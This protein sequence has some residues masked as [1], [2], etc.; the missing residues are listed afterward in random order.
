MVPHTFN[1]NNEEQSGDKEF[2]YSLCF[3]KKLS[4]E[5]KEK[6]KTG[7]SD[8][9]GEDRKEGKKTDI[10]QCHVL[11]FSNVNSR[12]VIYATLSALSVVLFLL[13][14]DLAFQCFVYTQ[15]PNFSKSPGGYLPGNQN[16]KLT[17]FQLQ[18]STVSVNFRKVI[19][20]RLCRLSDLWLS[21]R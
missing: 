14:T 9:G 7:K 20:C 19:G 1:P 18:F 21:R 11:T 13:G 17:T 12:I 6:D 10:F 8:K 2:D 16:A 15:R 5:R 3:N 4:E